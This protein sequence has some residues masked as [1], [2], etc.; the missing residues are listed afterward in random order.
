MGT[1]RILAVASAAVAM[2]FASLAWAGHPSGAEPIRFVPR[3]LAA[4]QVD[5]TGLAVLQVGSRVYVGG[6]FGQRG[7]VAR[8]AAGSPW[9]TPPTVRHSNPPLPSTAR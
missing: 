4:D 7:W 1:T 6:T 8:P 2:T 9:S 3:P 5:G